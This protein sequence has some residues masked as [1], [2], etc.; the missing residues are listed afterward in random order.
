VAV[1]ALVVD[2]RAALHDL[3]QFGRTEGLALARRAPDL[4]RQCQRGAAVAVRHGDQHRAR[5]GIE[6]QRTVFDRLG[7][8]QELLDGIAVERAED[9]DAGT[10][11]ERRVELEGR[12]LGRC[13]DQRHRPVFHDRQEGILLGAVEAV[14]LVDEEERALAGLAAGAGR[15]EGLLQIGNAGEDGGD[16][17]EM[18]IGLAGE[19][20]RDGRLARAGR[21]P[22]DHRAERARG[23]HT[24]ERATGAEE[25]ILPD[26][27]GKPLG[28][29]PVGERPRRRLLQPRRLEERRHLAYPLTRELMSRPPR[30]I[31]MSQMPE[32]CDVAPTS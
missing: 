25:M 30:W 23:E 21:P 11:Q 31:V 14:D 24:G 32:D 1:L 6:R 10:R 8:R 3:L 26:D 29:K 7:A 22:E 17:L 16:L 27:I 2:R 13:A 18:E 20:A 4:F 5:I 19:K 9:E 12:V 28:P 15:L